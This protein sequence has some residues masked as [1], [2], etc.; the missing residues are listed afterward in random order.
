MWK[1]RDVCSVWLLVFRALFSLYELIDNQFL[2]AR[3][4]R[5]PRLA[6]NITYTT[7]SKIRF[8][9]QDK[10]ASSLHFS[11]ERFRE[12]FELSL[13]GIET[14]WRDWCRLPTWG[15]KLLWIQFVW[16]ITIYVQPNTLFTADL[17]RRH[18]PLAI[19]DQLGNYVM[20]YLT[21]DTVYLHI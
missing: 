12:D 6:R 13:Y 15:T 21:D 14:R 8:W 2:L 20:N 1:A 4:W 16:R 5:V 9:K 7:F 11:L 3:W 10:R 18:G 17:P 19:R